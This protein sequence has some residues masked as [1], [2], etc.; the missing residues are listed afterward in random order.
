MHLQKTLTVWTVCA[1]SLFSLTRGASAGQKQQKM[2]SADLDRAEGMLH[3]ARDAVKKYY[4]DPKYHG[5]DLD[6]RYREYSE[7]IKEAPDLNDGMRMVAAFLSGLKDSHTYFV[8][9]P[10]P[11]EWDY[12]FRIELVGDAGY[13]SRLRPETD[14]ASQLQ[15]GDQ[16]LGFNTYAVNRADF[17]D[18]WY[19]FNNLMPQPRLQLDVRDPDGKMRRVMVNCKF[20]EGKTT[21]DFTNGNDIWDYERREEDADH[22]VRQRWVEMGDIMVWKMPEFFM[23]DDATDHIFDI[24]RKH[25]T[26]I[27]DLRGNPGGSVET[28]ERVVGNVMDH[29]VTIA[30][31][32]SRKKIKPIEAKSLGSHAFSGKLIV[33]VDSQ[34]ASAAELFARTMQLERRGIVMG[35][36]T[37][38]S[39]MEA[40]A[41]TYSQGI[42]IIFPY[43]FSVTAA[44]LIMKDG[45]S[46]EHVGVTPD[47]EI[48]PTA[49]D[50]NTGSDPVLAKAVAMA[51]GN[52]SPEAAGKMFPYEWLPF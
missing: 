44:D 45:Q 6:A 8:P 38:G 3:D 17:H 31:P 51:G 29:D 30:T 21:L 16:I 42:D 27:L 1:I 15:M 46:L 40:K 22:V 2:N 10:R 52:V 43:A 4:Y 20:K 35:D 49:Q 14:A 32:V 5:I 48:I 41:Y 24:A 23:D 13:I 28:L 12:G 37:S 47:E 7:R 18:L 25:K 39:V 9:P 26:L 11:Y 33:L 19:T 34:S 50:L 36:R